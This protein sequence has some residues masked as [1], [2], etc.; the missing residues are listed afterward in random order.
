MAA[1]WSAVSSKGKPAWKARYSASPASIWVPCLAARLL[2]L[3]AA[4]FVER[5]GFGRRSGVA[6]HEVQR[7]HGNIQFVAVGIFEHEKLAGVPG[8]VHGL[9]SGVAADPVG[10]VHH[11]RADAEVRQFFEY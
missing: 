8:D 6:G 7:L 9:Q 11:R 5:R 2:P 1:A 10:F 4:E 3:L